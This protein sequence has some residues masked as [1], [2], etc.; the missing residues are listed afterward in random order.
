MIQVS[1]LS[2]RPNS[3]T[4]PIIQNVSISILEGELIVLIGANGSGKSTILR[5]LSGWLQPTEG[6][7]RL[8]DQPIQ[9]YSSKQRAEWIALLPQRIRLAENIR[10]SEW[11]EYSRYRFSESHSRR[12]EVIANL[13]L[14]QGLSHLGTQNFHQLSGGEAQRISLLSLMAQEAKIWLLDEPGNHLDPKIQLSLYQNIIGQ[15]NDGRTMVLLHNI[16][17]L[18]RSVPASRKIMFRSLSSKW[19]HLFEEH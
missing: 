16:N 15:W 3:K 2:W 1:S 19:V 7:V 4:E 9:Q 5:S 6:S 8:N 11:L 14:S 10:V 13:L 18:L 12:K 17:L